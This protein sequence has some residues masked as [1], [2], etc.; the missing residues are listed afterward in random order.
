[1][2]VLPIA[3]GADSTVL[4]TKTQR[5]AK[6]SKDTLK[7]VRDLKDT[8]KAANGGGLAAPQIGVSLRVC[9]ATMN[10]KMTT[11]INPD[12][13]WASEETAFDTEGC[14]SLPKLW[15]KIRRPKEI[16]L[17]YLDEK[18]QEQERKLKGWDARVV[19][20]EVDHLDGK[21]IVDYVDAVKVDGDKMRR[22]TAMG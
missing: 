16:T 8:V 9:L 4:H 14:L 20:H 1:M 15:L 6:V 21:L 12:I 22:E 17:K 3:T 5:I 11:L 18:G 7:V 13:S 19:Q 10:G 2:A